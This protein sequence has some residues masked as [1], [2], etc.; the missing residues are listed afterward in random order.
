MFIGPTH[1]L[2]DPGFGPVPNSKTVVRYQN[3]MISL[4]LLTFYTNPSS[5]RTMSLPMIKDLSK[6]ALRV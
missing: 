1:G 3:S 5:L 4:G 6:P 2:L